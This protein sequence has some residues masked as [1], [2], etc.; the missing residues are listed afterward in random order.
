M[1]IDKRSIPRLMFPFYSRKEL[2]GVLVY[3]SSKKAVAYRKEVSI[4]I[5][6]EW[7]ERLLSYCDGFK[8]LKDI[9]N[10]LRKNT[11]GIELKKENIIEAVIQF[12]QYEYLE[13]N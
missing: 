7:E 5:L 6:E 2:D 1:Q 13:I 11:C 3:P 10:E 12:V 4:L 8:S 9:I